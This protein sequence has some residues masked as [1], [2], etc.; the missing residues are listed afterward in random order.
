VYVCGESVQVRLCACVRG[1]AMCRLLF[2][3]AL[4]AEAAREGQRVLRALSRAHTHTERERVCVCER[5]RD[6]HIR[7]ALF[8]TALWRCAGTES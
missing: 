2:G 1:N 4:S 7:L 3:G 5:E 8:S 6:T